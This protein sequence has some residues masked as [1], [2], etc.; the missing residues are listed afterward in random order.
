MQ[1]V[2]IFMYLLLSTAIHLVFNYY[3]F[4]LSLSLSL[5]QQSTGDLEEP[6]TVQIV[7]T[8]CRHYHLG[9]FQ[10]N[11]LNLS[12]SSETHTRTRNLFWT[13]DWDVLFDSCKFKAGKPVLEGYNPLLFDLLRGFH[14]Q[15]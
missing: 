12:P 14:A 2:C 3:I 11:T 4:S 8:N 7:H 9:V 6:I 1:L 5:L 13:Q 15:C 10:L